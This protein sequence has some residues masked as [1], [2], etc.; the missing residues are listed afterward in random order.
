MTDKRNNL[1]TLFAQARTETPVI[2]FNETCAH[3]EAQSG[4]GLGSTA[5]SLSTTSNTIIMITTGIV[6]LTAALVG[7]LSWNSVGTGTSSQRIR[8]ANG[9]APLAHRLEPNGVD[10]KADPIANTSAP[11]I[12]DEKGLLSGKEEKENNEREAEKD[13]NGLF[14]AP[15]PFISG[16][17][18][19]EL[20]PAQL[21][22][23]GLQIDTAGVWFFGAASNRNVGMAYQI[24]M[25]GV[26]WPDNPEAY[27]KEGTIPA[28]FDPVFVTDDFGNRRIE[29]FVLDDATMKPKSRRVSLPRWRIFDKDDLGAK[30]SY[31]FRSLGYE[32][33]KKDDTLVVTALIDSAT[34]EQKLISI[35][36]L[37]LPGMK[38]LSTT[39]AIHFEL[40][41]DIY[42]QVLGKNYAHQN[43][44]PAVYD[45]STQLATERL[46]AIRVRTNRIYTDAD[47]AAGRWRPDC[48]FWY[49]PTPEFI[50]ALPEPVRTHVRE[51]LE[52]ADIIERKPIHESIEAFMQ[53]QPREVQIGFDSLQLSAQDTS[54]AAVPGGL[55]MGAIATASGA[56]TSSSVMPN[57]AHD[58]LTVKYTLSTPRS[59][60]LAMYDITG[61]HLKTLSM[62]G[63]MG[64]GQT[65]T[66]VTVKDL[67]PGMYL[68]VITTE[69]GERA[70]QRVIVE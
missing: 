7:F 57:P 61:H 35:E 37:S 40:G 44:E 31:Y 68:L 46:V 11:A 4:A 63:R 51:A 33:A 34:G 69:K 59:V 20:S 56:I 38:K 17:R 22:R 29:S 16:V 13:S 10:Q 50:V 55:F 3:V 12:E 9:N 48:I 27:R 47:K 67:P 15:A 43:I 32:N 28:S 26:Q 25:W 6:V 52:Y 19:I 24:S 49:E 41:T 64:L 53:R 62:W 14:R 54:T 70:V 1:N 8:A 23:L 18:M 66:T 42:K 65:T 5:L 21:G 36:N 45:N 39:E 58:H 60:A 30:L 2:T